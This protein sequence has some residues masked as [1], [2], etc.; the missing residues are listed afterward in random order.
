MKNKVIEYVMNSPGNTNRAV[1]ESILKTNVGDSGDGGLVTEA[2]FAF[3]GRGTVFAI[4]NG[5]VDE[6]APTIDAEGTIMTKVSDKIPTVMWSPWVTLLT[7]FGLSSADTQT[8][9]SSF[10]DQTIIAN[11]KL[12]LL[13]GACADGMV[14]FCIPEGIED[15]PYDSGFYIAS[16]YVSDGN[17]WCLTGRNML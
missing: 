8:I 4:C 9:C 2:E 11:E 6:N 5:A 15:F 13:A 10:V 1:L 3:N 7:V 16:K 14:F 17:V 12:G